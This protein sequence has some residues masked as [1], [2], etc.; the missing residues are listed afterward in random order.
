MWLHCDYTLFPKRN[1]GFISMFVFRFLV[2]WKQFS[3]LIT[4]YHYQRRFIYKPTILVKQANYLFVFGLILPLVFHEVP[5]I[6]S[7][8]CSLFCVLN[9]KQRIN[10]PFNIFYL[11]VI[12]SIGHQAT[13]LKNET[14]NQIIVCL[15]C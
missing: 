2:S 3:R 9:K 4:N 14:K 5:Q 1:I 7:C 10:F 6:N 8:R 15:H 12:F 13:K 11:A